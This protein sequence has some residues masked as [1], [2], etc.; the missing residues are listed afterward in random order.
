MNKFLHD[1]KTSA[2][3]FVSEVKVASYQPFVVYTHTHPHTYTNLITD[4]HTHFV[5]VCISLM[6]KGGSCI[7]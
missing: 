3:L 6:L 5:L 4:T 1:S 7:A 2:S